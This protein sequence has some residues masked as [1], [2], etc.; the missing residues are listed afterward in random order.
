MIHYSTDQLDHL[1]ERFEERTLPKM[2]WTHEAHLAVAIWYLSNHSF[3]DALSLVREKITHHNESVGTPNTDS[4]GYHET[5]TR[6]W[7]L[8]AD[9][10]LLGKNRLKITDNCNSLI[11]ST[12]GL[13]SHPLQY[14]AE[15]TL[16]SVKARQS[17]VEPDLRPF[18]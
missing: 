6:F 10:F 4:E 14:Y 15:T 17:W 3:E 7:L 11:T 9:R 12:E 16:F 18:L 1:I 8:V 2:E 13:S 5:I